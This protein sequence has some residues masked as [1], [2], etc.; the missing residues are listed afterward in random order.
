MFIKSLAQLVKCS[1]Q[2]IDNKCHEFNPP[3]FNCVKQDS[4]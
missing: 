3:H 4:D 1:G 2:F